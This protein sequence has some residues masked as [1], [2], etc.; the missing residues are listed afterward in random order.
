MALMLGW[1]LLS[2]QQGAFHCYSSG[3]YIG[4]KFMF[5]TYLVLRDI[6]QVSMMNGVKISNS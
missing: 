4:N 6:L 5:A 1:F 3:S 2:A